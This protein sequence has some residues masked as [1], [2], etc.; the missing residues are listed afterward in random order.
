MREIIGIVDQLCSTRH[1]LYKDIKYYLREGMCVEYPWDG[2]G[3]V[4]QE[5]QPQ[6]GPV[7]QLT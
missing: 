3:A 2:E 1:I 6:V 7:W 5:H 4:L